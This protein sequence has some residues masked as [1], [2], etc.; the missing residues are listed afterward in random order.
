MTSYSC[1]CQ[2]TTVKLRVQASDRGTSP[3]KTPVDVNINFL[4]AKTTL[5]PPVW[6]HYEGHELD[7]INHIRLDE[8]ISNTDLM[9][10]EAQYNNSGSSNPLYHLI[11]G[12]TPQEN[13]KDDFS[14]K[15]EPN[16]PFMTVVVN[17]LDYE[18]TEEYWLHLRASVSQLT[19]SLYLLKK[20]VLYLNKC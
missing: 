12:R 19:L 15:Q 9:D 17:N 2:V 3:N 10:L 7:D 13:S 11:N 6:Q 5:L 20:Q 4:E 1:C 8:N 14:I 18:Q 16:S